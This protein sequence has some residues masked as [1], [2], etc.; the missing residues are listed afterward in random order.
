MF[1]HQNRIVHGEITPTNIVITDE[2]EI[3]LKD[4]MIEQKDNGYYG[5][6]KRT[7]IT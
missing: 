6:K 3:K 4:W 7:E 1:L 5:C 2:E